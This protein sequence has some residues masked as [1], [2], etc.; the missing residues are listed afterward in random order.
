MPEFESFEAAREQAAEYLGYVAS[1]KIRTPRGDVFEI[2]N[3]SLLDDEQQQRYD[4][5]QLE[6]ESWDRH[7]D[8][9]N[10]DGTVKTRGA[11]KE[12][13]R[14]GN[15]LVENYNTQLAKAIFGDR[16][17]AFKTAGGRGNDVA[18]VWAK[19][20]KVIADRRAADSKSA[21]SDQ[22][23]EAV[24]HADSGGSS[25]PLPASDQ[26]VASGADVQQGAAGTA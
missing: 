13:A 11:I 14:K 21:G 2:P 10:E 6:V 3:P 23:V 22:G 4:E 24:P 16:Y 7:D 25:A 9:L 1:E 18:F 19:M 5:L 15:V 17:E 8:V 12:P 20:N 26:G